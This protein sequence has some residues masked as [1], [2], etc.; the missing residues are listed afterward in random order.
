[1]QRVNCGHPA[2]V[3]LRD[4]LDYRKAKACPASA[5]APALVQADKP[6]EN[7]LPFAGKYGISTAQPS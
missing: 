3:G 1:M 2:T 4:R 6:L 7:P 5:S